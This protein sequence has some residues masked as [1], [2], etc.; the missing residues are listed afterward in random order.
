MQAILCK[1]LGPPSELCLEFLPDPAPDSG[2]VVVRVEVVGL[3]F[4]DVLM[5]AGGY[6]LKPPLPF[7]PGA[8]FAGTVEAVGENVGAVRV[9]NRVAAVLRYGAC[10][11][12]VVVRAEDLIAVPSDMP[13]EIAG[14]LFV[15]Y[16]TALHALRQRGELKRGETLAI[17]G[18]AGGV[19][20]AAVEVGKVLG[21]R[22]I[23]CVGSAEK[24]AFAAALGAEETVNYAK[25]NLEERLKSL[26]GGSGVDVILDL[27]G[28]PHSQPALRSIA[29]GGR[30][31]VVGFAAGE[32]PSIPL[33]LV[34][35]KSCDIRGVLLG[36]PAQGQ[37]S[38]DR[39]FPATLMAWYAEGKIRPHIAATYPLE[40]TA[41]GLQMIADRKVKGKVIVRA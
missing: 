34:L 25:E 24:L 3:S 12:R 29:R 4:F 30:Y 23:A 5:I 10:R 19:G 27:V 33:N 40:E 37:L 1:R 11:E 22:V 8:E 41:Q 21:A 39:V 9:G 13:V 7:S 16:G 18:A 38:S 15:A 20:H 2:E 17:L 36:E 31:L 32:I 35:L 14:S 26:T 6:Q 28:G